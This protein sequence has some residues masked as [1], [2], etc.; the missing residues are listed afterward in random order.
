MNHSTK[1]YLLQLF[2]CALILFLI[3]SSAISSHGIFFGI[4]S[5]LLTWS[6][7]IL[8]IPGAHGQ[9]FIGLPTFLKTNKTF[10]TEPPMWI[11]AAILNTA[12]YLILP[13]AYAKSALTNLL[14]RIITNA[15][16]YWIIIGVSAL[17]TFYNF[18]FMENYF[19]T[20]NSRHKIVRQI[21]IIIGIIIFIKLTYNEAI[22]LFNNSIQSLFKI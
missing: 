18:I 5:T 11:S 19:K 4:H 1:F 2:S 20:Q 6:F 14:Y 21:I 9:L 8:C 16:Y 13:Q 10:Y 7:Y 15:N 12:T 17:G 3:T 22:I